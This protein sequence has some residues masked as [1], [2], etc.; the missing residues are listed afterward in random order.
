ML[1]QFR[2]GHVKMK[3]VQNVLSSGYMGK[4]QKYLV[5]VNV[6]YLSV[7]VVYFQNQKEDQFK[8]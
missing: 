7:Q 4:S 3:T 8:I 1:W 2:F 5:Q 6:M